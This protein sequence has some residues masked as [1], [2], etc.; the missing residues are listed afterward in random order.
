MGFNTVPGTGAPG[1]GVGNNGDYYLDVAGFVLYGPKAAGA[2]PG[3]GT[4]MRGATGATGSD[5]NP[6]VDGRSVLNGSAAPDNSIG[7]NG[8]FYLRTS[9]STLYGPKASGVWPGSGV[10][11]IGPQGATG[12]TGSNGTNGT[13]GTDGA[14][15]AKG[16][17]GDPGTI[18]RGVV[19]KITSALATL[20]N[21]KGVVALGKTVV[22]LKVVADKICRVRLYA[23]TAQRD[24]DE[25][26]AANIPPTA[27]T[28]HGVLLDLLLDT[29]DKLT[30]ILSP[31]AYVDDAKSSPDG[32]IAYTIGNVD[33]TTQ[34]ITVNF[35]RVQQES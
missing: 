30:W 9:N 24:A 12:A 8:D 5:G 22:I 33:T 32:N 21:E 17:P 1:S 16:D 11:L 26:R 25:S 31:P 10:S 7:N 29:S 18:P 20:A 14:D 2:W 3:S 28:Q 23:T 15:G 35:T 19:T 34:A 27:G 4:P 13:D 6:G